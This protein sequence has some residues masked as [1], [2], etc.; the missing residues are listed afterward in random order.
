MLKYI[1]PFL[2]II[3]GMFL[4]VFGINQF[5]AYSIRVILG[6]A[7][8]IYFW[9]GYKEIKIKF[10]PLAWLVGLIIIIV[11]LSLEFLNKGNSSGF[12]PTIY[13]GALFYILI[14]IKLIGMV[15]VAA[16]IEEIFM[17]SFLIRL[18]INTDF[19]KVKIGKFTLFSFIA[20]TLIFGFMHGSTITGS[21]LIAGLTT[22]ALFNLWLYYRKDIF[23]CI[24]CHA[25]ANLFLAVYVLATQNWLLW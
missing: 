4:P 16:V 15:I 8:I 2:A 13:N 9:K 11:W 18:F 23:S 6:L 5:L 20:T 3:I 17:R 12:N 1:I 22:G 24:Q 25:A 21:R 10:D 19:K 7:A 14:L